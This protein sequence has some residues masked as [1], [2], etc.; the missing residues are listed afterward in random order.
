MGRRE[1]AGERLASEEGGLS[2][3]ARRRVHAV[4]EPK[5]LQRQGHSP[6]MPERAASRYISRADERALSGTQRIS[7]ETST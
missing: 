5:G 6:G 3:N 1:R 2:G 4:R 7:R